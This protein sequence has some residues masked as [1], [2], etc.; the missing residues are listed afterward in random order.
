MNKLEAKYGF[1]SRISLCV[2]PR[3]TLQPTHQ[4]LKLKK[5][6]EHKIAP[7]SEKEKPRRLDDLHTQHR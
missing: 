1:G 2:E 6:I 3:K 4:M 7:N 5:K